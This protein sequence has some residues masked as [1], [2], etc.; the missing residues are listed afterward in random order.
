MNRRM[1]KLGELKTLM[2][3][4][5]VVAVASLIMMFYYAVNYT[6]YT[7]LGRA[8]V[9]MLNNDTKWN[10]HLQERP[11]SGSNGPRWSNESTHQVA[12]G[13]VINRDQQEQN[14][15]QKRSNIDEANVAYRN[16]SD[17]VRVLCPKTSSTLGKSSILINFF[18]VFTSCCHVCK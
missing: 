6:R 13:L 10:R 15:H 7:K 18:L 14:I 11:L 8:Y 4:I 3:C 12:E 1:A 16:R 17:P 2:L 5:F 9:V